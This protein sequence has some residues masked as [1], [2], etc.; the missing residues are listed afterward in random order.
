MI[1]KTIRLEGLVLRSLDID[2]TKEFYQDLL[3]TEFKLEKNDREV[4]YYAARD[5]Q[6]MLFEIYPCIKAVTPPSPNLTFQVLR[7]NIIQERIQNYLEE[8]MKQTGYHQWEIL[9]PDHRKITLRQD[10]GM[11]ELIALKSVGIHSPNQLSV[12][13]FY[14]ILL[15]VKETEKNADDSTKYY[16][17]S[18]G[19]HDLELYPSDDFVVPASPSFIF[20]THKLDAF[21]DKIHYGVF[22]QSLPR[23][24][25]FAD[26]CGR[27]IHLYERPKKTSWCEKILDRFV[28]Y[29]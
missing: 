9:D 7:K 28:S 1:K 11:D 22:K 20:E 2:Q 5:S 8:E 23:K 16:S 17:F 19:R 24:L 27:K 6:R 25:M 26:P 21:I 10:E 3:Q 12:R 18:V 29:R 13:D 15:G 4:S 14:R